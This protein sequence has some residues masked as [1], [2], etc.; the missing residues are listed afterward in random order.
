M[1]GRR[2]SSITRAPCR[3]VMGVPGQRSHAARYVASAT[4][5]LALSSDPLAYLVAYWLEG[6]REKGEPMT[7]QAWLALAIV[8]GLLLFGLSVFLPLMSFFDCL[9]C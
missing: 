8:G 3:N 7:R 9:L 2:L 6:L 4:W 5:Y 1:R